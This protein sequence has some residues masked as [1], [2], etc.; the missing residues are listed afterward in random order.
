MDVS[1][2]TARGLVPDYIRITHSVFTS[3]DR[4]KKIFWPGTHTVRGIEAIN[5]MFNS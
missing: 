5:L 1:K 4:C 2:E 3:C